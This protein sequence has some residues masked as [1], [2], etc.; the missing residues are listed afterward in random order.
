[1]QLE[2]KG[3]RGVRRGTTRIG[4][5]SNSYLLFFRRAYVKN[6]KS[7]EQT[8]SRPR[9]SPG[10]MPYPISIIRNPASR[11]PLAFSRFH[12]IPSSLTQQHRHCLLVI[13]LQPG[14]TVTDRDTPIFLSSSSS[15]P[16]VTRGM[17]AA[18]M[19]PETINPKITTQPTMCTNLFPKD[20][21]SHR[22]V[23]HAIC[24]TIKSPNRPP[25]AKREWFLPLL[26]TYDGRKHHPAIQ[27]AVATP[28][29]CLLNHTTTLNVR[30]LS[31]HRRLNPIR[32][33]ALL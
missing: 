3:R 9:M 5:S 19:L 17:E 11:F 12:F 7:I 18:A 28:T 27:V 16:A 31:T 21:V 10:Q 26:S 2:N 4:Q 1:M 8:A 33:R 23:P 13:V 32:P 25:P 20:R 22:A 24:P 29:F 15:A 6:C 14:P 30:I